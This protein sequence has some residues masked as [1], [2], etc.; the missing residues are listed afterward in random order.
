MYTSMP[1]LILPGSFI[2][3]NVFT[4]QTEHNILASRA[5]N[6]FAG[7]AEADI[8]LPQ[9]LSCGCMHCFV[10]CCDGTWMDSLGSKS[11]EPQSNGTHQIIMYHPGVGSSDS[12][13]DKFTGGL[14]GVGLDQAIRE[15]YNTICTSYVDG[16]DIILIGSSHGAFTARSVADIIAAVALLMPMG[17]D[18]FYAMF[19][20]HE[21]ELDS[22]RDPSLFLDPEVLPYDGEKGYEKWLAKV[23]HTKYMY[24]FLRHANGVHE[25]NIKAVGVWDTVGA[26]GIT[27]AP[28]SNTQVSRRVKNAFHA[29]SL[30]ESQYTF[31]HALWENLKGNKTNLW[32]VWFP[33]IHAGGRGRWHGQQIDTV[34]LA[35]SSIHRDE[36]ECDGKDRHLAGSAEELWK[37]ARTTI[38]H[39]GAFMPLLNTNERIHSLA[40]DDDGIWDCKP[41]T[42]ADDGSGLWKLERGSGLNASEA[43]S[44]KD[45]KTRELDI[46][47]EGGVSKPYPV[48]KEDGQWKWVQASKQLNAFPQTSILP[49]EPLTGYWERKLFALTAGNPD[50][51]R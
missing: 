24:L 16:D 48:E 39:P 28:F 43:D 45:G 8:R 19:E 25:I 6:K 2:P 35:S 31:R 34:T 20:D 22:I 7:V 36:A 1:A 49:K 5:F 40:L 21:N 17:L 15:V 12:A 4:V 3:S 26:I 14:F 23:C 11:A 33:G 46:D 18:H 44:V 32:Q 30:D 50:V 13:V 38:R 37:T 9:D 10:V 27:P 29:L 51:W 41:L 42:R 47:A